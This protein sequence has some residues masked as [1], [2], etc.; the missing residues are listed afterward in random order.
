MSILVTRSSL[1]PFNE[2]IEELR[3]IWDTHWLTNMGTK[4]KELE[5]FFLFLPMAILPLKWF[6]KPWN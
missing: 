6:C 2:Y 4:H 5:A 3:S 1:P